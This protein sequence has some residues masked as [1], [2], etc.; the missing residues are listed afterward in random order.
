MSDD[1]KQQKR[2][3]IIEA[4]GSVCQLQQL[5]S[6]MVKIIKAPETNFITCKTFW[7]LL[8]LKKVLGKTGRVRAQ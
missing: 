1:Y 6:C 7:T 5:R 3:K 8:I 2:E 4:S